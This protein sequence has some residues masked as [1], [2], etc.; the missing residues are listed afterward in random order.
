MFLIQCNLYLIQFNVNIFYFKSMKLNMENTRARS[1]L[2][3]TIK[4][5]QC[6]LLLL[7]RI[8][9]STC[10]KSVLSENLVQKSTINSNCVLTSYGSVAIYFLKNLQFDS[11]SK[12]GLQAQSFEIILGGK[13]QILL[14]FSPNLVIMTKIIHNKIVI[15]F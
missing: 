9:N 2:R 7:N 6:F 12:R 14:V 5:S 11:E 4:L 3:K 13:F 8:R 1:V 10:Q 15:F